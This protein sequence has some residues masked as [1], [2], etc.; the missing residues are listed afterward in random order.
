MADELHEEGKAAVFGD[1]REYL[2]VDARLTL[3]GSA[4]A[5]IALGPDGTWR[6]SDRGLKELAVDRNGWV[7]IAIPQSRGASDLGFHCYPVKPAA[8]TCRIE[9]SRVLALDQHYKP[10]PDRGS[11]T[12]ELET[13]QMRAIALK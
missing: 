2:Y 9:I 8:G 11:G 10:G 12:L 7:R 13:G 6:S 4:V 5:A 3:T 1:V